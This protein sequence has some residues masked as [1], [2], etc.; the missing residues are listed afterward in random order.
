MKIIYLYI[1][2][3]CT[4]SVALLFNI[5]YVLSTQDFTTPGMQA[6]ELTLYIQCFTLIG[7]FFTIM[8]QF[9]IERLKEQIHINNNRNMSQ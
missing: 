5:L 2:A 1:T 4:L 9:K 7:L 6:T 8:R 3:A